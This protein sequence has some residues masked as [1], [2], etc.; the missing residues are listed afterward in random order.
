MSERGTTWEA[1]SCGVPSLASRALACLV[2][3]TLLGTAFASEFHAH[4]PGTSA[5]EPAH[6]VA[7]AKGAAP[8]SHAPGTSHVSD[9]SHGHAPGDCGPACV[10]SCASGGAPGE[11]RP[12]GVSARR[13]RIEAVPRAREASAGGP[14]PGVPLRPPKAG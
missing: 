14:S 6:A 8:D 10:V 1:T 2:L 4:W 11:V 13:A 12:V 7:A 3:W 5:H 9:A